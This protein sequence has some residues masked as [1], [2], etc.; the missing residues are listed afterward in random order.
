MLE[1]WN[2]E[3]HEALKAEIDFSILTSSGW[4]FQ[5][6]GALME[7]ALSP[8]FFDLKPPGEQH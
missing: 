3:S 4:L 2:R 6:L 1:C 8:L 7:N 5:S